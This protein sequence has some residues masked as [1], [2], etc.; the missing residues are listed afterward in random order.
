MAI[1]AARRRKKDILFSAGPHKVRDFEASPASCAGSTE[2]FVF[3]ENLVPSA[4][5]EPAT[6]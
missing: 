3:L 1:P 2:I 4:G 5:I 6:Y